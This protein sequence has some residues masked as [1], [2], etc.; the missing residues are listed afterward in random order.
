[1]S[2]KQRDEAILAELTRI[3]LAF[4]EAVC[5]RM[6]DH[7]GFTVRKRT[8]A[9]FLDNHHGDG[10]RSV[11]V[12][13]ALGENVEMASRD[14]ERFYL[15]AYLAP[16]G[17]I[18]LRLDRGKVDWQEVAELA[19]GSYCLAAPKKLAGIVAALR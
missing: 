10:I 17:W 3:C 14:P 19:A 16:K 7:A 15:P 5:Q 2:M 11:A 9:Y 12:K 1:M 8:F 18:A 6:G 13:A 4:P